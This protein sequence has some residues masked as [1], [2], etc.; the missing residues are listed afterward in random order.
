M[1]QYC[2]VHISASL[3]VAQKYTTS[4]NCVMLQNT[5]Y[6][7]YKVTLQSP[8]VTYIPRRCTIFLC[9]IL[10]A[11]AVKAVMFTPIGNQLLTSLLWWSA[12]QNVSSLQ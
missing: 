4:E 2:I 6:Y 8:C 7:S 3:K 12:S 9:S 5:F 10:V 11:L 1:Q